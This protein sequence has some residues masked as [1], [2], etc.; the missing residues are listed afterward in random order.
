MIA[1]AAAASSSRHRSATAAP[2]VL[3]AS[4]DGGGWARVGTPRRVGGPWLAALPPEG[5]VLT[6]STP[7]AGV[8]PRTT[9]MATPARRAS[10]SAASASPPEGDAT[11]RRRGR[12]LLT[13]LGR[14]RLQSFHSSTTAS[15]SPRCASG[16]RLHRLPGPAVGPYVEVNDENVEALRRSGRPRRREGREP[17]GAHELADE[18]YV[19]VSVCRCRSSP[20]SLTSRLLGAA[21]RLRPL[22]RGRR[23]CG[24]DRGLCPGDRLR[25]CRR[26]LGG[27]LLQPAAGFAA[28]FLATASAWRRLRRRVVGVEADRVG[29][30]LGIDV[31]NWTSPAGRRRRRRAVPTRRG[32]PC[33]WSAAA[34]A[35]RASRR[36]PRTRRRTS[37][38]ERTRRRTRRT[39]PRPRPHT[40]RRASR[41]RLLVLVPNIA[42]GTQAPDPRR[43]P[44]APVASWSAW[45]PQ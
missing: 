38:R 24:L 3:H 8:P 33:R 43:H 17:A 9:A 32:R 34:A 45:K 19:C 21:P 26:R 23:R 28:G 31:E 35:A 10:G 11:P 30:A 15:S 39:R 16:A 41:R 7:T 18:M 40:P 36:S 4:A 5:V 14:R 27:G 25:L 42:A 22:R 37:C 6:W 13:T 1:R 12:R 29:V 20:F 44:S 2:S